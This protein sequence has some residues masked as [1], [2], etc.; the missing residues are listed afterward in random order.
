M[1]QVRRMEED[2]WILKFAICIRLPV[3]LQIPV[4]A[5]IGDVQGEI[6][7]LRIAKF[8]AQLRLGLHV[9]AVL[10]GDARG[11]GFGGIPHQ[12]DHGCRATLLL[13][14]W[15]A[16]E[17]LLDDRREA[18]GWEVVMHMGDLDTVRRAMLQ[19]SFDHPIPYRGF[20]VS[21]FRLQ[22]RPSMKNIS[23]V[24]VGHF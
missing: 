18:L 8:G 16:R 24:S 6:L 5:S 19:P 2:D 1:P 23:P 17:A 14:H 9:S 13:R 20:F 22:R 12:K 3:L 11:D 15:R 4:V 10:F 21:I 7:V